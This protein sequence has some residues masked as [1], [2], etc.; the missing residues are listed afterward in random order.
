MPPRGVCLV[1]V[2]EDASALW[3]AWVGVGESIVLKDRIS[4]YRPASG[5][6]PG[7]S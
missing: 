6:P 1:Q 2:T 7:S 3:D 4:L 5:H